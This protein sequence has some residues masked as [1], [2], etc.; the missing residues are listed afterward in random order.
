MDNI[1]WCTLYDPK[2]E[3]AWKLERTGMTR[4]N[5]MTL[6]VHKIEIFLASILKFV[7]FLY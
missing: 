1:T 2:A 6:K 5:G 7:L 4:I 3:M